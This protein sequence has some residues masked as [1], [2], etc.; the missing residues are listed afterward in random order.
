MPST[1]D[2]NVLGRSV[3]ISDERN[4]HKMKKIAVLSA[5]LCMLTLMSGCSEKKNSVMG[6]TKEGLQYVI[7]GDSVKIKG[8]TGSAV[9]VKIPEKIKGKPVTV[10]ADGAFEDDSAVESITF[11]DT[12]LEIGAGAFDTTAWFNNYDGDFVVAGKV[13][14]KYRGNEKEPKI[15]DGITALSDLAFSQNETIESITLPEAVEKIGSG[16]FGGCKAL[17]SVTFSGNLKSIESGVFD[18][19][20][21]LESIKLPD[22]VE[23]I[24]AGA[25]SECS[26]LK[27]AV[28]NEG[29]KSIGR[30][31]FSKCTSL[32]KIE[33]PDTLTYLEYF[34]FS[35]CTGLKELKLSNSMEAVDRMCFS[36]C[37]SL[38]EVVIPDSV[39]QLHMGCFSGCT[40]LEKITI[41]A[42]V[43]VIAEIQDTESD[44]D[45]FDGCSKL[46]II[47]PVD[48]IAEGYAQ[49]HSIKVTNN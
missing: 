40:S 37:K 4:G 43:S 35:G 1:H 47:T 41:P 9:E 32:E 2:G 46:E 17:K 15:P 13:I 28:I 5:A 8:Y 24:G 45:V 21:A 22:S 18:S 39:I 29:V 23:S 26:S 25:F 31:A 7:D 16:A 3:T 49:A 6:E 10:I 34:A 36:E 12:I 42:T 11:P 20:S 14:Y 48:S 30:N 19:C 33:L 44:K 27:E 38:K